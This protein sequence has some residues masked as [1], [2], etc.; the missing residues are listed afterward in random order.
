MVVDENGSE[1]G[2]SRR[3]HF[4]GLQNGNPELAAT[5]VR[6]LRQLDDPEMASRLFAT[7]PLKSCFDEVRR[8]CFIALSDR[9]KNVLDEEI[10]TAA[11]WD[12]ASNF[13]GDDRWFLEAIGIAAE[14]HWDTI[15]EAMP[16]IEKI[17]EFADASRDH[18][19]LAIR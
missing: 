8:E 1:R 10:R 18:L 15:F 6:C 9:N 4:G 7:I 17:D 12:L 3:L 13:A 16:S 19:A 14:S 5:A 11:F 2:K